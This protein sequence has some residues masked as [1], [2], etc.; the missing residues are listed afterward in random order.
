MLKQNRGAIV[1]GG[2]GGIGSA[3]CR[4]LAKEGYRVTVADVQ[5]AGA[6]SVLGALA[7]P[8]HEAVQIDVTDPAS[9]EAAFD[10][11]EKRAPA[12]VLVIAVGGPLMVMKGPGPPTVATM[13]PAEWSQSIAYN[14]TG[15][16][17]CMRKFSQL[18]L[19][20]PLDHSRIISL[21]SGV[22]QVA[23]PGLD[24]SYGTAKAGIIGLTRQVAF[25]LSAS[26]ITV[27]AVAPG[28]IGTQKFI[29]GTDAHFVA[30][31]TAMIPLKRLGTP[32]EV[33]GSVAYLAS[34]DASYITGSTLDINGGIHMH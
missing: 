6:Q 25:E 22:G 23:T 11:V 12:A 15:F 30:A 17:L 31:A 20:Q 32:E 3:V 33:A 8:G 27:N 26:G 19:A 4:R 24:L 2:A 16:F 18:R 34:T 21:S 9:V 28:P 29:E 14:L 5:L 1:V 13:T 7:G 10:A